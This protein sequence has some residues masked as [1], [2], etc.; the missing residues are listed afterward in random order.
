LQDMRPFIKKMALEERLK[1]VE[2][3]QTAVDAESDESLDV[4]EQIL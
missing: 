2:C 1:L 4:S 3:L